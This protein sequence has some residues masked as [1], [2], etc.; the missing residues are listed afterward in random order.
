MSPSS[1]GVITGLVFAVVAAITVLALNTGW[2][3]PG[4]DETGVAYLTATPMI[5]EGEE[6]ALPWADWDAES[7]YSSLRDSGTGVPL[8][9][10]LLMRVR[11]RP[12]VV[13]LWTVAASAALL[14][15][16]V[17]WV[18]GGVAGIPGAALACALLVISG[19]SVPL[20]LGV[21]PELLAM[22][23][24]G[25]QLGL[26]TYR[27]R[28]YGAQGAAAAFGW[29]CHPAAVGAV[30]AALAWP[31]LR[32]QGRDR[33]AGLALALL[34]TVLL[35]A[36]APLASGLFVP[37]LAVTGVGANETLAG[38]LR[39]L[40]AGVQG[41]PGLALG[42]AVA[43]GA[44]VLVIAEASG[45]PA[46]PDDVHW[47]DPRAHDALAEP[48]RPAA[49]LLGFLLFLTGIAGLG[50]IGDLGVSWAPALVPVVLL[51]A[52]AI[53]RLLRRQAPGRAMAALAACAAIWIVGTT[54]TTSTRVSHILAEGH[55]FTSRIWVES[56]VVRWVD[57]RSAGLGPIYSAQPELLVVQSGIGSRRLPRT[58]DE[59]DRFVAAWT[60]RP[61]PIVLTWNRGSDLTAADFMDRLPVD[62]VVATPEG[63][64]LLP[65]G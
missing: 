34:P 23:A 11:P 26:M 32:S 16:A 21:R 64:V 39:W 59:L 40:G 37:S 50:P 6:P 65:S 63:S 15:L 41:W 51:L 27:P 49:L 45:S 56:E 12:F 5:V 53:T 18:A 42:L 24:V 44:L 58:L 20:I 57:N 62:E 14:L 54:T 17:G 43:A 48:F 19:P 8:A 3:L 28:G 9:M 30:A 31:V 22:A 52:C 60:E 13:A 7:P 46:A 55:G 33:G 38:G 61:G 25:L 36:S 4:T 35:F 1:R 29:L 2:L 10:S 47:S